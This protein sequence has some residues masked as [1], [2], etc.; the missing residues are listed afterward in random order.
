MYAYERKLG[1]TGTPWI[2]RKKGKWRYQ[3]TGY[4]AEDVVSC[5]GWKASCRHWHDV[6]TVLGAPV[7]AANVGQQG[8]DGTFFYLSSTILQVALSLC[9]LPH[10]STWH[11]FFLPLEYLTYNTVS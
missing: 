11:Q 1:P 8:V 2:H 6:S 5:E 3:V 4:E 7:S 9:L 10:A